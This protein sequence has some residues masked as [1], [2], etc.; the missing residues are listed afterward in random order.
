MG[1]LKLGYQVLTAV[2][3]GIFAGLFFGPL[4][5]NLKPIGSVYMMLLQM[6]ALPYIC[7]SLIHGLGSITPTTGKKLFKSGWPFLLALWLM[8]FGIIFLLSYLIPNAISP[9]IQAEGS[10]EFESNFTKSFLTFLIPENPFYDIAN[11][12]VPA[13]AIFGLIGGIALMH[14]ENKEPLIGVLERINQTI[15]K[16]LK[17][18]GILSPI[19]AFTYI[20]VAFGTIHFE[21]IYKIEVYVVAFILNTLFVTLWVLPTLISS[22]TPLTYREVLRAFRF[23]CL[24]PFVTGIS[25]AGLPFI[26]NYLRRLS[27]KHETHENFRETSQTILPIAYSFGNIGNAMILFFIFFL[28]YYYR[29]PF[30][31]TETTLLSI[32]SVPLSIGSSTSNISS[33]PFLITELGFPQS[34]TEFFEQIKSFTYNFQVMM[35]IASVLTL[36]ILTI[37]SYYGLLQIKWK[38]CLFRLGTTFFVFAALVFTCKH[39]THFSDVYESMYMDHTL[40]AVV[41]SPRKVEILSQDE[42]G[43]ARSFA[44]SPLPDVMQQIIETRTLKVGFEPRSSI[45]FCYYN[46]QKELVGFDIAY[47]YELARNINCDLQL[48]PFTFDELAQKLDSGAFDIGMSSLIMSEERLLEMDFTFPYYEDNNVLVIPTSEKKRYLRLKE[49]KA[50]NHI[51]I[52]AVGALV[53]I[54]KQNFPNATLVEIQGMD[55]LLSKKVESVFWSKTSAMV[56]CLTHP[57]FVAVDYGQEIGKCYFA[58]PIRQHAVNFGFFLNNWL[59]LKEQSGFKGAMQSYWID[60]LS[61]GSRPPRWSVLRNVFHYGLND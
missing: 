25:A 44:D 38:Q 56:W 45:P 18:L 14:I 33:I 46:A 4:T 3:L 15:E 53:D 22:M 6:A 26:N 8:I 29:H 48:V 19:G 58:Y 1:R 31:P 30:S 40:S 12:I 11:N 34:S 61:P 55:A 13:V 5:G 7:F 39:F 60:G 59:S 41:E 57:E 50:N 32:L 20:S 16:I 17:W 49:L 47:A 42:M 36:I 2:V 43:A 51:K 52:G 10:R 23:V 54:A 24:L 21:D 9:L 27:R 37:Y 28:S 35:S